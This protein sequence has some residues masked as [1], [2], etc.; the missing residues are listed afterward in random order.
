MN[1]QAD[2]FKLD[3]RACVSPAHQ[4]WVT[5][6]YSTCSPLTETAAGV[7]GCFSPPF[8]AGDTKLSFEFFADGHKIHDTGDKGKNDCGL[9]F[10]GGFWYPDRIVRTGTYHYNVSDRLL[11][12]GVTSELVPLSKKAG[13]LVKL[14]LLNRADTPVS[15][16]IT[17]LL[18]PGTP[19]VYPLS[20]W[21]FMPPRAP[22][23]LAPAAPLSGNENIWEN[24]QA[25]LT[26][27]TSHKAPFILAANATYTCC[28]AVVLTKAGQDAPDCENLSDWYQETIDAWSARLAEVS[29]KLPVL[30]SNIDG[31]TEYYK[32]SLISLLVC[33]WE[34]DQYVMKPFPATSGIDGGSL[35][36]YPWDA[37]GYSAHTLVMLLGDQALSFIR[38]MLK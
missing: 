11:S 3:L 18:T 9:L 8:A 25:R 34:N 27:L 35:C 2:D 4:I 12:I 21:E 28:W 10:S 24:S 15:L 33:L 17:P 32:R 31:L 36:C 30:T 5:S 37:A 13:F 22:E 38:E 29:K 16:D 7:L 1:Y 26:L 23:D 20:N 19:H 6:G 14:T